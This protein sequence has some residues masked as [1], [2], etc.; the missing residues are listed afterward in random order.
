MAGE[1]DASARVQLTIVVSSR[2]DRHT[3]RQHV[4]ELASK[5][6]QQRRHLDPDEFT[7]LYGSNP[8]DLDR[9]ANFAE[10]FGLDVKEKS[11]GRRCVV[12]EGSIEDVDRALGVQSGVFERRGRRFRS[13]DGSVSVPA[14]LKDIIQGVL[15]LDDRARVFPH[16]GPG[17]KVGFVSRDS[18]MED[19]GFP[20][21]VDGS[22][23][24]IGIMA[25]GGG[26]H[27]SDMPE[28]LGDRT[29]TEV[30]LDGAT[31]DPSSA[32]IVKEAWEQ[33]RKA[34]E[35]GK[36]PAMP[37]NLTPEKMRKL[38][39]LG[40]QFQWTSEITCD[41][42]NAGMFAPGAEIVAYFAPDT[43]QG[44]YTAFTTA[45]VDE[46]SPSVLSCSW[47]DHEQEFPANNIFI[48]DDVFEFAAL[49]GVTL[50]FSSGDSGADT[51]AGKPEA[52]FPACSPHVLACGGTM[53][54]R[55]AESVWREELG[56]HQ[57]A[58]GGGVSGVFGSPW[59]QPAHLVE[60]RAGGLEGRGIP[61][62]AGHAAMAHGY[63]IKVAGV[64]MPVGGTSSVAPMWAALIARFNQS[65]GCQV[66]FLTPLLYD[67]RER[68][69][70]ALRSI[71]RGDNGVYQASSGWDACTGWGVPRGTELLRALGAEG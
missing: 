51:R 32:E 58:S 12:I 53:G 5:L 1:L 13:H 41:I 25:L 54:A 3:R 52:H 49:R 66:G 59:W 34:W 44:K 50:C 20:G 45:L 8:A 36:P 2:V 63:R 16:G 65:L 9:V 6:P 47:G 46:H 30:L 28:F 10:E 69:E 19:Y 70:S 27:A 67:Q 23:Q 37:P 33:T 61:D 43:I 35:T 71:D 55:Q 7:K 21:G 18:V 17:V 56:G 62:V 31:N 4:K 15:G 64:D 48:L 42:Q 22:G 24:T 11:S 68:F 39:A 38:M 29:V 14:D 40:E 60:E 26:F 57:L